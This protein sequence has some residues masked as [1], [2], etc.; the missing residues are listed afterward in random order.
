ME[1]KQRFRAAAANPAV[2]IWLP[3]PASDFVATSIQF[4][5]APRERT[6]KQCYRDRRKLIK[7]GSSLQCLL[8]EGVVRR[9]FE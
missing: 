7:D 5:C 4:R 2:I 1:R 8:L 6:T 9:A 3:Y